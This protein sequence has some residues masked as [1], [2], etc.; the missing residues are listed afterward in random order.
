MTARPGVIRAR[1]VSYRY[2]GLPVA[3]SGAIPV[4]QM[5]TFPDCV[6][7]GDAPRYPGDPHAEQVR[8]RAIADAVETVRAGFARAIPRDRKA[9]LIADLLRPA[10]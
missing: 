5:V 2:E 1:R 7:I 4:G 3:R 8:R 9:E 10:C 6:L